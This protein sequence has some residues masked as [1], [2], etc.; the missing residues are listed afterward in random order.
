MHGNPNY[1][2]YIASPLNQKSDSQLLPNTWDTKLG[3]GQPSAVAIHNTYGR[4]STLSWHDDNGRKKICSI[5]RFITI[6]IRL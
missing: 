2:I 6:L 4:S 5:I 3:G 1:R